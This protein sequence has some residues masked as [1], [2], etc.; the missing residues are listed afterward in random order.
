MPFE[1][2]VIVSSLIMGLAV[3]LAA[4]W[5]A[6]IWDAIS[7]RNIAD[8]A[9]R[10]RELSLDTSWLKRM[11][12]WWGLSMALTFLV[13]FLVL[14]IP[15]IGVMAVYVI[16]VMPH[17]L[18][19][20][21]IARRRALLRDQMVGAGILLANATRAGLALAQG[22]ETVAQESPEPL[23]T[24]F[25]R[26]VREYQRG[27]PLS[28]ALRDAKVRL[29]LDGFTLLVNAVLTCLERG[30]KITEALERISRSLLENQ[31]LE[32]KIDADTASGRLVVLILGIFPFAFM[33]FFYI[34]APEAMSLMFSTIIGQVIVVFIGILVYISVKWARR[35]LAIDI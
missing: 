15:V 11:Q 17:I 34:M 16:Y 31:R 4:V 5:G 9:P 24:E 2:L 14:H 3:Y 19:E 26:L 6:P 20:I 21:W 8:L 33:G 35:I 23:A 22:L 27:R 12:R 25:R 28:D 18:L 30:G 1:P 13:C 32:R 7:R 29:N 10:M